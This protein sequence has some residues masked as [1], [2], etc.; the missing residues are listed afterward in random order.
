MLA[1]KVAGFDPTGVEYFDNSGHHIA[2]RPAAIYD[3]SVREV[4]MWDE[5]GQSA[6]GGGFS[7]ERSHGID[8]KPTI[9]STDRNNVKCIRVRVNEK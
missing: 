7:Y 5:E 1:T 2:T 8:G 9:N 4:V 6:V 3:S